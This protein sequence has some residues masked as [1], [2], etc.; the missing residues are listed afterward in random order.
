MALNILKYHVTRTP[1]LTYTNYSKE[2]ELHKDARTE[3]LGAVVV[4]FQEQG[5]KLRVIS[6]ASKNLGNS[7]EN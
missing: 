1:I 3:G 2:Y 5:G 6:Y 7:E 4:F